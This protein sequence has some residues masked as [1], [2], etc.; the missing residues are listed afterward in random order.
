M[1]SR[2]WVFTLNNYTPVEVNTI[3]T[4]FNSDRVTYAVFGREIGANGTPHL[5]GFVILSSARRLVFCRRRIAN[6]A[7]FQT[8]RGTSQQAAD[9]CKKDGDFEEFG[10]FPGNQGR[11]TDFEEFLQW[12]DQFIE[13]HG[14]AP[15]SAEIGRHRPR[16]FIRFNRATALFRARAPHANVREGE[17]R[18]WQIELAAALEEEPDDRVVRFMVD[19]DGGKGKTWFQQWYFTKYP[20]KVQ[21]LSVGKRDDL[22]F[23]IDETKSVFFF[24]VPRGG[25][26]YFQYTIC[27]QLKDRMVFSPKYQSRLKILGAKCHVCVFCNEDPDYT[28]MSM[29]RFE[30]LNV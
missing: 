5:Q 30:V 2:R 9:Y 16:E 17:P 11:R 3:R 24:N 28:K 19:A 13:E 22:A 27:E 14:R 6:R 15:T 7:H 21:I 1:S 20:D 29:D 25:M 8:A 10:T 12:G 26:E 23:A 18:D 4:V